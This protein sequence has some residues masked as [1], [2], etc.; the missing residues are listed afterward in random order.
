MRKIPEVPKDSILPA[1]ETG[2]PHSM[3]NFVH[4]TMFYIEAMKLL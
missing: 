1:G 4:S 3:Y 2:S